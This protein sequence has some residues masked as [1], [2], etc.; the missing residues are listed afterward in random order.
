MKC[1]AKTPPRSRMNSAA[2]LL[3][4][5][6]INVACADLPYVLDALLTWA[7][8]GRCYAVSGVTFLRGGTANS[9]DTNISTNTPMKMMKAML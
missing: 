9:M 7:G 8:A 4:W 6:C 1:T 3:M 2:S 5:N